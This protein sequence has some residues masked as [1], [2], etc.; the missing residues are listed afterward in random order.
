[1]DYRQFITYVL[2][3]ASQIATQYFGKAK[4]WVKGGDHQTLL[5][6]A[7]LDIG[8]RIIAAVTKEYPT[9]NIIE[10]ETGVIDK[11]S[12]YTWVIDSIDGTSNFAAGTPDYGVMIGLLEN[13]IPVAG[14]FALPAFHEI[15]VAEKGKGATCNGETIHVTKE[16]NLEKCLIAF[17][18]HAKND[19]DAKKVGNI[20]GVL[21]RK[22]IN[23]RA[24]SSTF[25][26]AMVA[27][28]SYGAFVSSNGK[29]WDCV[30]PQVVIEE[31]GGIFTHFN[32]TPIDYTNA[33]TT[34]AQ[35]YDYFM[36]N[37]AIHEKLTSIIR[38]Q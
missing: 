17:G 14:G 15:Y 26:M 10:E 9:H 25:D 20:V 6:E 21:I 36:A 30:G 5:T 32:G 1:M 24:S 12:N 4:G 18:M 35:K 13:N 33:L 16:N 31:A 7:D 22:V 34:T 37:P 11:Q 27:K 38:S 23:L 2:H 19:E 8:K 29:I 28:G 3:D